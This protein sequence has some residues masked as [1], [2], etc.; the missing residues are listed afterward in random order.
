MQSWVWSRRGET[1]CTVAV[2]VA[3]RPQPQRVCR[4]QR[5]QRVYSAHHTCAHTSAVRT[6]ATH[7]R[8][9]APRPHA[10]RPP[11]RAATLGRAA[12]VL[13]WQR[14][15]VRAAAHPAATMVRLYRRC[16]VPAC[17]AIVGVVA[18]RRTSV[19]SGG[20]GGRAATA[21]ACVPPAA[22]A[23]GAQCTPR[24]LTHQC[25]AHAGHTRPD[26]HTTSTC[27]TTAS[28]CSNA[29]VGGH[30]TG[31]AA[32]RRASG[33]SPSRHHGAPGSAVCGVGV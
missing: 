25:R 33:C 19:H 23:A 1:V 32:W 8:T 16:V 14:G 22:R 20:G 29:R 31:V 21:S 17:N 11:H 13:V 28:P 12:M 26:P 30:G 15:A 9:H 4:P 18:A 27:T 6:P 5:V 10:Q 7:T 3:V 2:V 24:M